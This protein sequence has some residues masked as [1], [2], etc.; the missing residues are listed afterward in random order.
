MRI[1]LIMLVRILK[2]AKTVESV[3][4]V[5]VHGVRGS[6]ER[7][8]EPPRQLE[9]WK[10]IYSQGDPGTY[11]LRKVC[12]FAQLIAMLPLHRHRHQYGE[13]EAD[14]EDRKVVVGDGVETLASRRDG[15]TFRPDRYFVDLGLAEAETVDCHSM[16]RLADML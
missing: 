4:S 11:A 9:K 10:G 2:V 12:D 1:G 3:T 8:G 14:E 7:W 6:N 16:K 5:H 13:T 15:R